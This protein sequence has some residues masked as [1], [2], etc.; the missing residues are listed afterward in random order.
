MTDG[1]LPDLV[2]ASA[3]PRR[4]E[5]LA[6]GVRDL[7]RLAAVDET[8]SALSTVAEALIGG[9]LDSEDQALRAEGQLPA[10]TDPGAGF[11]VPGD[12]I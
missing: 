4:R 2:L 7:M 10:R 8:L 5:L 9:A 1:V 6:V 3:S 12:T 11:T